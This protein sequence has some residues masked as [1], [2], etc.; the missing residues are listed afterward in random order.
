MLLRST[1]LSSSRRTSPPP[2]RVCTPLSSPRR[3]SPPPGSHAPLSSLKPPHCRWGQTQTPSR[4]WRNSLPDI[5]T[6]TSTPSRP[7]DPQLT[8][9][10]DLASAALS[11]W[12]VPPP[13]HHIAGFVTCFSSKRTFSEMPFLTPLLKQQPVW[14]C[15]RLSVLISSQQSLPSSFHDSLY[16]HGLMSHSPAPRTKM[17]IPRQQETR[18]SSPPR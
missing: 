15:L 10:E 13:D 1:P 5:P 12:K 8:L 9:T 17:Y 18:L 11:A 6:A 3:P 16:L 14:L 7:A 2:S 4:G